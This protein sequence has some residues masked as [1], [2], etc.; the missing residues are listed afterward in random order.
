MSVLFRSFYSPP[1][2]RLDW[3]RSNSCPSLQ[4]KWLQML[5]KT[6]SAKLVQEFSWDK[7][8]FICSSARST[9][10]LTFPKHYK[11]AFV[12][13]GFWSWR[14]LWK[15]FVITR[16]PL[17]IKSLLVLKLAATKYVAMRAD[18]LIN[19]QLEPDQSHHRRML[20]KFLSC[21]KYLVR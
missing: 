5:F 9:G 18:A 15:N 2:F 8:L 6:Y 13:D 4:R 7:C 19:P 3:L 17:C 10:L 21:V 14:K 20:M 11:S 1:P 16:L 12:E